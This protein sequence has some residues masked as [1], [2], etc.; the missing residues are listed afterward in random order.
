MKILLIEDEKRMSQVLYQLLDLAR[1]ENTKPQFEEIDFS[2]LCLSSIL[3]F[4]AQAFEKNI[5]LS[6]DIPD[7]IKCIGEKQS[8]EK[9][10]CILVDNALSNT[11]E[12]GYVTINLSNK[13][14][15]LLL[16]VSNTSKPISE[17]L[18]D[19]IF[20][21]FY[22]AD[23]SHAESDGHYG[24]GLSIA[25]SIVTMHNGLINF[26]SVGAGAPTELNA[27]LLMRTDSDRNLSAEADPNPARKTRERVLTYKDG[28]V[29]FNVKL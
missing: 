17:D 16:T 23:A 11:E 9:L 3:P 28:M 8:L 21:R 18:S 15:K 6:Y 22:R 29:I 20:E 19:K 27:P 7:Y 1:L 26:N 10:V 14:D 5:N 12:G 13:K 24:L 4:E 25:K 2:T